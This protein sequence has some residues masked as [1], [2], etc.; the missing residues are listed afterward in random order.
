MGLKISA[1]AKNKILNLLN[2][3]RH[4]KG[5]G[6]ARFCKQYAQKLVINHANKRLKREN[7]TISLDDVSDIEES[8]KTRMGFVGDSNV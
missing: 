8:N 3:A 4:N 5:F 6:N 1:S 2:K 7:F